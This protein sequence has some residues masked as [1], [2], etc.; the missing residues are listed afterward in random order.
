[1]KLTTFD[2]L[3]N[4]PARDGMVEIDDKQ[5]RRLQDLLLCMLG[6]VIDFCDA[7]GI[8]Y[9]LYGGTCLGAVRHHGFIPWDDDLDINMPRKDFERFMKLFP[10]QHGDA[11]WVHD[12][13]STD[14]L[15]LG[16]GRIRRK[17]TAFRTRD[18]YSTDEAGVF[19]DIFPVDNVPDNPVARGVHGA[20]S[21]GL[22]YLLSCRRFAAH[23]REY[24]A[25]AEGN[26]AAGRTFRFK[27]R[28]GSIIGFASIAGLRTIWDAWNS[29]CKNEDSTYVTIPAGRRYYFGEM[30]RRDVMY[31]AAIAE[32]AGLPAKIPADAD[33]Y[34]TRMHGDYMTPPAPEDRESHVVYA[35]DLG[36]LC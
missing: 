8:D 14:H 20:V 27:M 29:L 24:L 11:Y 23:E 7:N 28:V 5:L 1:M 32:F 9:Q 25:L 34:L 22:G 4:I 30:E 6:D 31:P 36:S 21:M 12:P 3:K 19:I 35:F 18:D 15:E 33:A 26:E 10:L 2:M 17:G 13:A 16:F